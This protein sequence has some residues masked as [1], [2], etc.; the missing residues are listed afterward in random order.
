MCLFLKTFVHHIRSH[1]ILSA[2]YKSRA[3][4]QNVMLEKKNPTSFWHNCHLYRAY[5]S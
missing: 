1:G 3:L 2:G 4:V 5:I